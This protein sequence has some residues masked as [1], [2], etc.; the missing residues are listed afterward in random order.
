[1]I[2]TDDVH[3]LLLVIFGLG[4]AWYGLEASQVQEVILV[5][6]NTVVYHAPQY[7]RGIINLRGK[8]VTVLD[9]ETKLGLPS[10]PIGEDARILIVAWNHEQVG[11]LVDVVTEV[12]NLGKDQIGPVPLNI[13]E[14]LSQYLSG[15]C[16]NSDRL[17]GILDLDK[18]LAE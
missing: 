7:V 2:D 3:S 10:N 17:I 8:I 6:D 13:S 5:E 1:M 15:V 18:V 12:I 16:N 9:M 4:G 11:L 14:G